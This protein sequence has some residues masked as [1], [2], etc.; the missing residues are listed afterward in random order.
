MIAS[1]SP[2]GH[3]VHSV[4]SFAYLHHGVQQVA[5]LGLSAAGDCNG[6]HCRFRF[7]GRPNVTAARW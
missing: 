6:L 4:D 3:L 5:C 7:S 1:L 2:V